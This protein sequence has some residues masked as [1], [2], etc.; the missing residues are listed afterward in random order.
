[1]PIKTHVQSHLLLVLS[2]PLRLSCGILE[3]FSCSALTD[4]C[5]T[6]TSSGPSSIMFLSKSWAPFGG[7]PLLRPCF[8]YSTTGGGRKLLPRVSSACGH[9][10]MSYNEFWTASTFLLKKVRR[11]LS[12]SVFYAFIPFRFQLMLIHVECFKQIVIY[13]FCKGSIW[14]ARLR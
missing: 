3:D 14:K 5:D 6:K 4:L 9:C 7:H 2:H 13:W 11:K 1:M 12:E 10:L 8:P